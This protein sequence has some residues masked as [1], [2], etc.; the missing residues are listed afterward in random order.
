MV[1]FGTLA[2]MGF[3]SG[4]V[5]SLKVLKPIGPPLGPSENPECSGHSNVVGL[6]LYYD[7]TNRP[8]RFGAEITPDPLRGFCLRATGTD[9]FLNATPPT[10]T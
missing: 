1:P 3:A 10:A 2:P 5:L 6:R 8:S 9:F 4:D 7:S